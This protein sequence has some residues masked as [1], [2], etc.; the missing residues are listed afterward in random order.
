MP[1][2]DHIS[3]KIGHFYTVN[4]NV[5]QGWF[6]SPAKSDEVIQGKPSRWAYVYIFTVKVL[7]DLER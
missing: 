1:L 2:Y 7:Q 5:F 6:W 3:E 4:P